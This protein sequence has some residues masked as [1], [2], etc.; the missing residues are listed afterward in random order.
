M[1]SALLVVGLMLLSS[2]N[3]F[4]AAAS[5][6]PNAIAAEGARAAE[7]ANKLASKQAECDAFAQREVPWDEEVSIGGAV[8]LGLA[9]RRLLVDLPKGFEPKNLKPKEKLPRVDGVNGDLGLYVNRVG[10]HVASFSSRPTIE[11]TFAVLEDE[12]I[13]AFSAPGGY[14][15]VTT[16]LLKTL[17]NEDQLAGVLGH[18]VGH[19]SG[20]HAIKAYRT[21]KTDACKLAAKASVAT[22]Y[23]LEDVKQALGPYLSYAL[24]SAA[25]F[26]SSLSGGAFD[27][28]K[29]TGQ[30][31]EKI[32][33]SV[34]EQLRDK[35]LDQ[36]DE[37]DAD[38]TAT[39]LVVFAGY[40]AREYQKLLGGLSDGSPA[41]SH[42]PKGA[43]R[44]E[45]VAARLAGDEL[46]IFVNP[47]GKTRP[48]GPEVAKAGIK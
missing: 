2:C 45:K 7:A 4:R 6:N 37:F 40:D 20:R 31:I 38:A 21:A 35:G 5:G 43:D 13:N 10:K 46:A 44:A 41:A 8:A 1:R 9:Q 22:E 15:F 24:D 14:V 28:D 12:S 30:V 16:G 36:A 11:W 47:K 48:L 26:A 39:D 25:A 18:E 23:G 34:I 27:P 3:L 29:L 42:H 19:V 33:D 17:T 32:T